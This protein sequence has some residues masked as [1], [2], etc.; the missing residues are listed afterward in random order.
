MTKQPS[1]ETTKKTKK[2]QTVDFIN[3]LLKNKIV[4]FIAVVLTLAV[5]YAIIFRPI[6]LKY[7]DTEFKSDKADI[8]GIPLKK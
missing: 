8:P 4:A 3:K 5:A 7:G 2:E 6:A 1:K